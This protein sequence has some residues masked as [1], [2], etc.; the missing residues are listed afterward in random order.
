MTYENKL[1]PINAHLL[2]CRQVTRMNDTILEQHWIRDFGV[3]C[4]RCLQKRVRKQ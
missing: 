3:R 1:H 2:S 4:L